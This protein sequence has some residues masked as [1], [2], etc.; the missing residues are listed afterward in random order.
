MEPR[1]NAGKV[2][3]WIFGIFIAVFGMMLLLNKCGAF[4]ENSPLT[5]LNT[6]KN[7]YDPALFRQDGEFIRYGDD[8]LLGVDVSS[9]QGEIDW[10]AVADA[11]MDFAIIRVAYRGYTDGGL[12]EDTTFVQNYEGATAAGLKVGAYLFSQAISESEAVDEAEFV[13]DC[14]DGRKLDLPVYYDWE[15]IDGDVRTQDVEPGKLTGFADAFC[16][17]VQRF[18]YKGGVYFN[19]M[20]GYLGFD[21][22]ALSEY[23]LWLAQYDSK[24]DFFYHFDMWQYSPQHRVAGINEDVDVNLR[25]PQ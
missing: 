9:H 3:L 6:E 10:Q 17:M 14:L 8:S 18:G 11:G 7:M 4:G 12:H 15:I 5:A 1:R 16:E 13:L 20:L 2:I 22:Q 21:L 24:P 23:D 19:Q 25:F